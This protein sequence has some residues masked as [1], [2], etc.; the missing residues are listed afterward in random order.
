M[1]RSIALLALASLLTG[2]GCEK[3]K[4]TEEPTQGDADAGAPEGGDVVVEQPGDEP[5]AEGSVDPVENKG[6]LEYE[7]TVDVVAGDVP[8]NTDADC[9][10]QECCHP[11]TC[12]AP[13]TKP[14]CSATMCTLE[15]KS[16]TM[17]CFG[18]CLC[19]ED[20]KC[21]AKIWTASAT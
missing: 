14:D 2:F 5:S 8:C 3:K 20:K 1:S 6:D 17:D 9:V 18:G 21:A 4:P 16:G 19:G 7:G 13:S 11:S 10:P 12:G 15:C